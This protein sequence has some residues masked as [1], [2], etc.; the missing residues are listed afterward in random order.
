[1]L[2]SS[3]EKQKRTSPLLQKL[4]QKTS[5]ATDGRFDLTPKDQKQG[6]K[7]PGPKKRG[8]VDVRTDQFACKH[9]PAR[10]KYKY[11]LKLHEKTHA[12]RKPYSC[13]ICS[14]KFVKTRSLEKHMLSHT[15]EQPFSCKFCDK[16]FSYKHVLQNH[17]LTHSGEKPHCCDV[18]G[19][20]FT[21]KHNM[22]KHLATHNTDTN[23]DESGPLSLVIEPRKTLPAT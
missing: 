16:K 17:L 5:N 22:L 20:G 14:K 7:K 1:M 21:M 4:L 11:R 3:E 18:C 8:K 23:L 9:C 6:G 13:D 12:D 19:K 15:G 10:F 2:L